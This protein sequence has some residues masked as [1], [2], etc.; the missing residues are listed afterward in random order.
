M[1]YSQNNKQTTTSTQKQNAIND[2]QKP[3]AC[4]K[5]FQNKSKKQ[6][7]SGGIAKTLLYRRSNIKLCATDK[8]KSLQR[9]ELRQTMKKHINSLPQTSDILK[10][11]VETLKLNENITRI[12]CWAKYGKLT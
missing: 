11:I 1:Q 3:L 8:L 7:K 6:I 10:S 2:T 12:T 9:S 4:K 5:S